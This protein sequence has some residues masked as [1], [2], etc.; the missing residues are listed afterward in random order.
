MIRRKQVTAIFQDFYR[1]KYSV[2]ENKMF[3]T[4][5][6]TKTS[7]TISHRIGP[8]KYSDRIIVLE[9]GQI[10]EDG[11]FEELLKSKGLYYKMYMA[12]SIWYENES[13]KEI[14]PRFR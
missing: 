3:N 5:S 6:Q 7:I 12:Q 2:R 14:Y 1:Y 9:K 10:V 13:M 4:L 11:C 8:T